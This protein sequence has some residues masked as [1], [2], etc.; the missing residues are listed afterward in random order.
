MSS[1]S[2]LIPNYSF[3]VNFDMFKVGFSKIS[4]ISGSAEIDTIINGGHNDAPVILRKPKRTPDMLV[5]ERG[6]HCSLSDLALSYFTEGRK[7]DSITINVRRD[8]KTVRMFFVS[9]AIIVRRE[10]APL[11]AMGNQIFLQALQV[12]HTGITEI[13]LPMPM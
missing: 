11:D 3:S 10:Y 1:A 13:A 6:L 8:G 5:F 7:V 2:T 9:N 12:A 4:N